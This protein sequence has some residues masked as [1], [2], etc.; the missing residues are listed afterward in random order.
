MR[1]GC[2]PAEPY[3]HGC[4]VSFAYKTYFHT[5][6]GKDKK[7]LGS[8]ASKTGEVVYLYGR[9]KS[10]VILEH[11]ENDS[12][13]L[14]SD[15]IKHNKIMLTFLPLLLGISPKSRVKARNILGRLQNSPAKIGGATLDHRG[16]IPFS[17]K[18]FKQPFSESNA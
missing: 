14:S 4:N 13:E 6:S 12:N 3:P 7:A 2:S 5:V 17:T 10:L 15:M 18:L 1:S 16:I 11:V 9:L 8:K